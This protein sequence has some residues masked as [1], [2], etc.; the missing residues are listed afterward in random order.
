V[1]KRYAYP[2]THRKRG[3]RLVQEEKKEKI[4][5][6]KSRRKIIDK[7]K[8]TPREGTP[9]SNVPRGWDTIDKRREGREAPPG[10]NKK[11]K[12][13]TVPSVKKRAAPRPYVCIDETD[14]EGAGEEILQQQP[15]EESN[16]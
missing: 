11:W 10:A 13:Q 8:S 14:L 1:K 12:E 6:A 4:E 16:V 5:S 7:K 9:S 3:N 2:L 15:I